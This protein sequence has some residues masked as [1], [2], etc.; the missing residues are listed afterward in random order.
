MEIV[1]LSDHAHCLDFA[2]RVDEIVNENLGAVNLFE[3]EVLR[4][5]YTV[6]WLV[7][8]RLEEEMLIGF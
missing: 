1:M 4:Q 8:E 2:H 3:P 6:P 7:V 5:I